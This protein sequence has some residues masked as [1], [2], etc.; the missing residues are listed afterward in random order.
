MKNRNVAICGAGLCGTLLAIRLAQKGCK[1][2][3]LEKRPDMRK[4]TVAAGRSINLALSSRGLKALELIGLKEEVLKDCIPMK[5]R[6][7]HAADGETRF[8]HYSGRENHHINSIPRGGLNMTLLDKADTYDNIS[9]SFNTFCESL[10]L[11]DNSV[12][13]TVKEGDSTKTLTFDAVFGADGAGS[14]IRKNLEQHN[15]L[16]ASQEFLSHGYKELTIPPGPDGSFRLEQNALHI[17]PREK[18]MIIALPNPDGS[19]T[20]TA[21]FPNEGKNSFEYLNSEERVVQFFDTYFS[22]LLPYCPT[23]LED[24]FKNPVGRLGTITC[25][26]WEAGGKAL[27]IGDAAHAIVPFYGQGMNASF[28]DV[29]VF[30]ELYDQ[31]DGNWSLVFE[32]YSKLRKQDADAIALLALDNFHEMQNQVI[33]PYFVKKRQLE[34]QLEKTFEQYHSKYSLVTFCE[35]IPYSKAKELGRKQD[36]LLLELCSSDEE[37]S[38]DKVMKQVNSLKETYL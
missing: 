21:F 15:A 10:Q 34:M 4:M 2:T 28:E 1:V 14:S 27:L 29:V 3:L 23:Y 5:G 38:L 11:V 12:Q 18:F 8:S 26:R 13:L 36:E 16:T 24:F 37:V 19:F 22:S 31:Y 25:S 7:I 9:T 6:M 17:W 20:V 33:H 30:D 32:E 35:H